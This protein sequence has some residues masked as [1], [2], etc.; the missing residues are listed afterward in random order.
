M[1]L[2]DFEGESLIWEGIVPHIDYVKKHGL[3]QF[4]HN[5]EKVNKRPKDVLK[6]GDE[7]SYMCRY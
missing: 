2:L 5:Y 7:V 4:L 1:G 6:W 3:I